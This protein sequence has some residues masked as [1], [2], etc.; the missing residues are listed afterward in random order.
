MSNDYEAVRKLFKIIADDRTL[1]RATLI[2]SPKFTLKITRHRPVDLREKNETYILTLGRPNY[3]E[4]IFI[5]D[6]I[7]AG[8]P[9][10]IK[11]AL[12]QSWPR[13]R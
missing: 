12:L 5:K 10:P 6:C 7:A 8:E 9:F 13:K 4:R 11:K 3:V 1:R 2:V